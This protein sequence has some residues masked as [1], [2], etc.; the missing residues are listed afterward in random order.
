VRRSRVNR[1]RIDIADQILG[2]ANGSSGTRKI[3]MMYQANL[4][5]AQ[6]KKYLMVLTERDL[7]RYD[8]DTQTFKTT[9]K[10]HKFLE[11]YNQLD[12]LM[13]PIGYVQV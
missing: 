4:S 10:G 2:A 9:E 3:K 11:T 12:E 7:L 8:L 5:Y 1:N 6:L 13:N